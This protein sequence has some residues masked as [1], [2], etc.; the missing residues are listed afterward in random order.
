MKTAATVALFTFCLS[1]CAILALNPPQDY[2]QQSPTSISVVAPM[3]TGNEAFSVR[4]GPDLVPGTFNSQLDGADITPLWQ[5]GNP[6]PNGS[7]KLMYEDIFRGGN[8]VPRTIDSFPPLSPSLCAHA[9]HVHGDVANASS[10]SITVTDRSV[11]FV[12]VQLGLRAK[13]PTGRYLAPDDTTPLVPGASVT[14]TLTA[15]TYGPW[16][17]DQTVVVA[18]LDLLSGENSPTYVSLNGLPPGQQIF[19]SPLPANFTV[20]I[21]GNLGAGT[22]TF[23]FRLRARAFGCQEAIYS[24]VL[25]CR[26]GGC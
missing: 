23:R 1:G 17:Q 24:G 22:G 8:C 2:V 11:D 25:A 9:L 15:D 13:D 18:A 20:T 21:V 5:P 16:P 3:D 4:F 19:L 6:A 12:P 14:V 26:S 10:Y 7:A